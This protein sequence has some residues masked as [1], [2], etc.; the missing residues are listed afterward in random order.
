ML[1]RMQAVY[2]KPPLFDPRLSSARP[3]HIGDYRAYSLIKMYQKDFSLLYI[4]VSYPLETQVLAYP[5]SEYRGTLSTLDA[6]FSPKV[7]RSVRDVIIR[8]QT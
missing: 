2:Q 3:L 8:L 6:S 7:R 1:H 4:A 5:N